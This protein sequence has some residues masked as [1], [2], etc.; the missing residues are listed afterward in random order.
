[1]SSRKIVWVQWLDSASAMGWMS[2]DS[3]PTEPL[4]CESVGFL[5]NDCDKQITLTL[6][7]LDESEASKP[8]CDVIIIPKVS[9]IKSKVMRV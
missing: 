3:L 8:F 7:L 6:S 2:R 1:M 9:V 5:L 4:V